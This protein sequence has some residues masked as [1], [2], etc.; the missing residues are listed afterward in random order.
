M[1]FEIGVLAAFVALFCWGIG[2]FL[3]QRSARKFGD[4]ETL[5]AITAIG[6][7]MLVPF[8]LED[9]K[10]LFSSINADLIFLIFVSS[11]LLI[12]ALL[13]FEAL[14]RGKIAV[15]EPV[16]ALEIPVSTTLAFAIF[17]EALSLTETALI[18]IIVAGIILVSTKLH[19]LQRKKWIEKGVI[20]ASL[21]ALFMGA[22]NFLVGY[23][24]RITNPLLTMWF[25]NLFIAVVCLFFL[26]RKN[27]LGNM[28]EDIKHN[29]KLML[30]VSIIDNLAWIAF[31]VSMSLIPIAISVAISESY[32][33]L[34]ALLGIWINKERLLAHQKTGLVVALLGA[35]MLASIAV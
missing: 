1:V 11:V 18:I 17:S 8:V 19:H 20:I 7:L 32:I 14:K 5:F 4:W 12:A 34:A 29:Q 35:V 15:I 3:I 22:S 16:L 31:A 2:D 21:G 10:P 27:R 9:M 33:A 13:D 26:L 6:V 23:A 24:S 25:T 28:V 30:T